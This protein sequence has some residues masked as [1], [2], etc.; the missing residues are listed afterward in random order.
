[1]RS[2]SLAIILISFFTFSAPS[3]ASNSN[4]NINKG[5]LQAGGSAYL[6][7]SRF[8]K[9]SVGVAPDLQYFV[10]DNLSFGAEFMAA[11]N[12]LSSEVA[13]GPK[14]AF[15][16]WSS[17]KWVADLALTLLL[18]RS[19]IAG[20]GDSGFSNYFDVIPST[21]LLYF[22]TPT[23]AFGPTFRIN[24]PINQPAYDGST[25]ISTTVSARLSVFF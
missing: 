17:E 7:Y 22:I 1:M 24:V 19:N 11:F 8:S 6:G 18:S 25:L 13:I 9:F 14:A 12:S 23:V 10:A 15:Y 20:H 5:N 16:F 2:I 4:A 21:A 3:F